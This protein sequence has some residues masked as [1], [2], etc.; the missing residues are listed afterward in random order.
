MTFVDRVAI[1][2]AR[3][4]HSTVELQPGSLLCAVNALCNSGASYERSFLYEDMKKLIKAIEAK[5]ER[6]D[7][8]V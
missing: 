4:V 5:K 8:K 6:R 2:C 7:R 3:Y 1:A